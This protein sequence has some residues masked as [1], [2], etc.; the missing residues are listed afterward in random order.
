MG[1]TR[2][3]CQSIGPPGR[4]DLAR[5]RVSAQITDPPTLPVGQDRHDPARLDTCLCVQVALHGSARHSQGCCNLRIVQALASQRKSA[6]GI[7]FQAS[8]LPALINSVALGEKNEM[9]EY[10]RFIARC[11][12]A[13]RLRVS[14][15][16]G[17]E[18]KPA[19]HVFTEPNL[20]ATRFWPRFSAR[21]A[22]GIRKLSS[23]H[24]HE[25]FGAKIC[26]RLSGGH[27]HLA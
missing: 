18:Q 19:G 27:L 14:R 10:R 16:R 6:G 23:P 15:P 25:N 26:G 17:Q 22:K 7:G 8:G 13:T 20:P 3:L 24:E 9:P 12:A 11:P 2:A 1:Q 21:S 4:A 5:R